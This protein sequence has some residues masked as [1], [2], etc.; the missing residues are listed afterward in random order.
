MLEYGYG[1][2]FLNWLPFSYV[3]VYTLNDQV[4]NPDLE[5]SETGHPSIIHQSLT[6]F[7][8]SLFH[9]NLP[10]IVNDVTRRE[11]FK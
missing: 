2:S 1:I 3:C 8:T 7:D 11:R 6:S 5:I 4:L 9:A 10:S